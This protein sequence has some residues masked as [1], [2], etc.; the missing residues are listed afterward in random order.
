MVTGIFVVEK[1]CGH[2]MYSEF[3]TVLNF[4]ESFPQVIHIHKVVEIIK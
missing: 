3:S 1:I 2:L 4:Q